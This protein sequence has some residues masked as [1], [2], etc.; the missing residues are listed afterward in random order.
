[1][2]DPRQLM[3]CGKPGKTEGNQSKGLAQENQQLLVRKEQE[4]GNEKRDGSEHA[5]TARLAN[6]YP[7]A[8]RCPANIVQFRLGTLNEVPTEPCEHRE[9]DASRY[10]MNTRRFQDRSATPGLLD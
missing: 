8:G 7:A 9:Q 6:D 3:A 5:Y 2:S 1:M 10:T 4:V